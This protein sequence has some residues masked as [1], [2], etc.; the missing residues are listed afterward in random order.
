MAKYKQHRYIVKNK[1]KY[2][3]DV[4]NVIYR[5]SWEQKCM[6]YFDMQPSVLE[7]S[8]EEVVI[9]YYW[10]IDQRMHRYYP[11]FY[12]KVK[13]QNNEIKQYI[14]EIKPI[15]D[16]VVKQPKRMTEKAKKQY[17]ENVLVVSKNKCKFEAAEKFCKE[18]GMIFKV[19]T[20]KELFGTK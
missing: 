19:L 11:D 15:K 5:S 12:I 1:E 20:E 18:K 9:P 17:I 13:T 6:I 16:T 2:V 8:S 10:E 4:D 7:W 3:G 14:L